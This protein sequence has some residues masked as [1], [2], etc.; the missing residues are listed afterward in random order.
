MGSGLGFGRDERHD[1]VEARR[2]D[3]GRQRCTC[4][5]CVIEADAR[6]FSCNKRLGHEFNSE[7][8]GF[9][10]SALSYTAEY[11]SWQSQLLAVPVDTGQGSG[12]QESC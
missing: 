12:P 1:L 4:G 9:Q 10:L 8:N 6:A 3:G 11:A 2:C 7:S 5:A